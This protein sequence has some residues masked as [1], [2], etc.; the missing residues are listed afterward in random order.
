MLDGMERFN[1]RTMSTTLSESADIQREVDSIMAG[2]PP[3][4]PEAVISENGDGDE[5]ERQHL[6][7]GGERTSENAIS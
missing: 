7:G 3:P 5:G 4:P 1:R 2:S 6:L